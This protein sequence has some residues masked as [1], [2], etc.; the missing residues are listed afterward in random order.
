MVTG[1]I[2]CA[3]ELLFPVQ[4]IPI[5]TLASQVAAD[6]VFAQVRDELH[7]AEAERRRLRSSVRSGTTR[8]HGRRLQVSLHGLQRRM[9]TVVLSPRAWRPIEHGLDS[10][11]S[12]ATE[13]YN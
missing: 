3:S 2:R 13:R 12:S 10:A 5:R 6:T 9:N 8:S 11:G 4:K 1:Q 7:S